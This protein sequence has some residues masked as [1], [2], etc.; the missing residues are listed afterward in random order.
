MFALARTSLLVLATSLAPLAGMPWP[1]SCAPVE[2]TCCGE[3]VAAGC[4]CESDDNDGEP[5]HAVLA[6]SCEC[7]HP[8]DGTIAQ[9]EVV[10]AWVDEARTG[11]P[12]AVARAAQAGPRMALGLSWAPEPPPPRD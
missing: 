6:E 12:D 3:E 10:P 8:T 2:T 4:C 1:E 7:G 5:A 11:D 9:C